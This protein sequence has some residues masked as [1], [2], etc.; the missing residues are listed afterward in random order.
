MLNWPCPSPEK[1]G[2]GAGEL[3][4]VNLGELALP[5]TDCLTQENWPSTLPG[6]S[7]RAGLG[8]VGAAEMSI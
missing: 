2:I 7:R 6:R 5:L 8:G 1:H 3:G 4:K